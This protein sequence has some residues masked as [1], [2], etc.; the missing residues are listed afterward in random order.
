MGDACSRAGIC[1]D[2]GVL[3][4]AASDKWLQILGFLNADHLLSMTRCMASMFLSTY[5][6]FRSC[7]RYSF[8][9]SLLTVVVL[10][11]CGGYM[12]A[13]SVSL[14]PGR[15]RISPRPLAHVAILVSLLF[16]IRAARQA[17]YIRIGLL[18]SRHDLRC[19]IH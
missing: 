9:L 8:A 10:L 6:D 11:V 19:G 7:T 12:L 14:V 15:V 4:I 13:G 3:R 17:G 16:L 5:S 18:D 1:G 2:C